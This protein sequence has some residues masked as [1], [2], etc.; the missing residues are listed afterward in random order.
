MAVICMQA[1]ASTQV[2]DNAMKMG[3]FTPAHFRFVAVQR[4]LRQALPWLP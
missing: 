1:G 3:W 4:L 2:T